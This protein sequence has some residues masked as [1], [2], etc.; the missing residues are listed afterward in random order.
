LPHPSSVVAVR[1]T[2]IGP[3]DGGDPPLPRGKSGESALNSKNL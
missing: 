2:G 1:L 3:V